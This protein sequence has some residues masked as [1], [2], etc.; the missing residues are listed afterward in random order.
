[1]TDLP[2]GQLIWPDRIVCH[3]GDR[4]AR[5]FHGDGLFEWALRDGRPHCP[6]CGSVA[7]R[8]LF[9]AYVGVPRADPPWRRVCTH[10]RP[11][12]TADD[13]RACEQQLADVFATWTGMEIA[14]QKY[15]WPHKLY[16]HRPGERE[17]KFYTAHLRDLP[18]STFDPVAEVIEKHTGIRFVVHDGAFGYRIT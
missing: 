9:D 3:A 16:L 10:G 5:K 17:V 1:M 2:S 6:Y 13:F 7:P 8:Y 18:A 15:G 11:H 14:D 12:L 4:V